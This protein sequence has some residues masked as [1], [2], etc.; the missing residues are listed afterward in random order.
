MFGTVAF[1]FLYI[2]I[3]VILA[4]LTEYTLQLGQGGM[5]KN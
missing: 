3:N 5:A 4:I 1:E 2:I